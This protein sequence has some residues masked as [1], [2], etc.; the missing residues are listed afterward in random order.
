[1]S[2][3]CS[4]TSQVKS[5][6]V[7]SSLP[8]RFL[9]LQDMF[10]T[11]IEDKATKAD[12]ALSDAQAAYDLGKPSF[13][14]LGRIVEMMTVEDG[15]ESALKAVRCSLTNVFFSTEFIKIL[16]EEST[17]VENLDCPQQLS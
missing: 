15:H 9:S 14:Q 6:P 5:L 11:A 3:E 7:C 1:M 2:C 4:S 12:K 13:Y 16:K 8:M 10:D 17:A